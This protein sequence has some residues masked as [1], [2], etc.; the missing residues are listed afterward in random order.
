MYAL[1]LWSTYL[2]SRFSGSA[3]DDKGE[4]RGG[5]FGGRLKVALY[6]VVYKKKVQANSGKKNE[7]WNLFCSTF[8]GPLRGILIVITLI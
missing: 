1:S 2:L 8:Q 5:S 3:E 4:K 7:V 6:S